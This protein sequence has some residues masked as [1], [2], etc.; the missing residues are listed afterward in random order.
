MP[1]EILE[2]SGT[3]IVWTSSGGTYAL[4]ASSLANDAARQGAK[5]DLGAT[6]APLF[7]VTC[8]IRTGGTAP[9]AGEVVRV[10]WSSSPSAT[11]GTE[12]DGGASGADAAY[13]GYSSNLNDSLRDLISLGEIPLTNLTNQIHI[14]VIGSFKP[15]ARYGMPIIVNRSGQTLHATGTDHRI[16]LRPIIPESQ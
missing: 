15:P 16:T 12:N 2:K 9:T 3:S 8:Q 5:G 6:R 4:D 1:T 13:T 11:A 7:V 14:A 10:F